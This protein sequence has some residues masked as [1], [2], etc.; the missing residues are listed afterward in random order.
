HGA[1]FNPEEAASFLTRW[2]VDMNGSGE[3]FER[4]ER[5]TDMV[6]EFPRIDDR[7]ATQPHAYG[8][9]LVTDRTMP[10]NG[11]G[12]RATGLLMNRI[13]LIDFR[14]GRQ[15]SWF[16]GPDSLIQEPCFVPR[17]PTSPEGDGYV[18]AVVDDVVSNYSALV[19]LDAQA[20]EE[21][22]LAR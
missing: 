3:E 21:G 14:T 20:L 11:P 18:F 19:V 4:T 6:G 22:P 16:C 1:P 2:T 17:T 13:A 7:Y 8:W 12:A 9:L 15:S 5:L 10:F